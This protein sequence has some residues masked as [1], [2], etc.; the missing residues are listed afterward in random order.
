MFPYST[1]FISSDP[2]ASFSESRTAAAVP[3]TG[4]ATFSGTVNV[5]RATHAGGNLGVAQ[6]DAKRQPGDLT[7]IADFDDMTRTGSSAL[8]AVD[9]VIVGGNFAGSVTHNGVG[10]VL[11]GRIGR[12]I[13]R[14]RNPTFDANNNP[15][16]E[17]S[18]NIEALA[19]FAGHW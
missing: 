7:L 12:V 18:S 8:V 11:I 14:S 4:F 13:V 3:V 19:A 10:G 15:V 9:G 16:Y 5:A 6:Y 2:K 1:K 17:T